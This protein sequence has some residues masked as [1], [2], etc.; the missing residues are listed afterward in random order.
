MSKVYVVQDDDALVVGVVSDRRKIKTGK[1]Q[2]LVVTEFELDG[3]H[4]I[5]KNDR[6]FVVYFKK[7]DLDRP[8]VWPII[9]G[10]PA[11]H[12]PNVDHDGISFL[13]YATNAG[14]ALGKVFSKPTE[15][16]DAV[17][18]WEIGEEDE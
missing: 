4:T 2:G 12:G 3:M 17:T 5:G 18:E 14:K 7:A 15:L 10:F 9:Q 16:G 6:P 13:V 1:T 11:V 8:N